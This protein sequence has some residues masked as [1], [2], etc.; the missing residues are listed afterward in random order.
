MYR[1][2]RMNVIFE[3][4]S[5]NINTILIDVIGGLILAFLLMLIS[6]IVKKLSPKPLQEPKEQAIYLNTPER[7]LGDNCIG[8]YELLEKVFYKIVD[9]EKN[10]I[11]RKCIT[12]TGEEGIGKSLFCYTLFEYDLKKYLVYLG[13]IDCNGKQS[14]FDIIKTTFKD[15][16]FHRKSKN[17]ILNAFNNMDKPCILFVDQIDQYTP[18]NEL[19]EISHCPNVILVLSGTLRKINFVYYSIELPPLGSDFVRVIFEKKSG[20]E[21]ILMDKVSSKSVNILLDD[22]VR[23]N[24]FLAIAV[25]KAKYHYNG[26]W[27]KVLESVKKRSYSEKDYL[28]NILKQLYKIDELD[29]F[30]RIA[31]SKLSAFEYTGFVESVFELLDI[32]NYCVEHLCNTYWLVQEDSVLYSMDKFHQEVIV[33]VLDDEVNLR[34]AIRAI[35][36]SLLRWKTHKDNGFKWVS[37]YIENILKNVQGYAVH[38]MDEEIFSK[39]SYQ[40]ACKYE[41]IKDKE[42][43]LKWI[44]LCK[45]QDLK[46]AYKKTYIELRAQANFIDTL[47]S[48]SEVNQSYLDFLREIETNNDYG[49]KSYILEEY[50]NFLIGEKRYKEAISLCEKYFEAYDIDLSNIYSC[51]MFFRFLQVAN[52]LNDEET[53][54]CIISDAIIQDLYQNDK[55][56]IAAAWSFGELGEIYKKWGNE[57]TSDM[58]IRHMVVLLNEERC[59]FHDDI[60]VNLKKTDEEFAEYMHSCDELLNSLSDALNK[61]D[62]EALYIEGRYQEKYGNYE[63]AIILYEKAATRDSLRGMCSLA[64]LY[65]RGQGESRDYDKAR[66]YW[67]YCCERGHRGSHYWLGILL[68]DT[69]YSYPGRDYDKDREL[70]LKH[71]TKAAELGSEWAKQK[72]SEF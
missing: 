46:L 53:L 6:V 37:V 1:G 64:L 59:F 2:K 35:Y 30:E 56:S 57:E 20:E 48:F 29:N 42:N 23:G 8:R 19:E 60:K 13:W 67:E 26:R 71:L 65:Y 25:A 51:N 10:Q 72:L 68:L 16:R 27:D 22:Y 33:K 38:I 18:I 44:E 39:L 54:K 45:P 58:Y 7:Y 3:F 63:D 11:T 31:L 4:I 28:K 61:M 9:G 40:V 52:L 70:A 14:I 17:D 49:Q 15:P 69:E 62:A 41:N 55:I 47:F 24:P 21:I 36:N 32:S 34:N 12:I 66:R 43:Q 50:C 5:D